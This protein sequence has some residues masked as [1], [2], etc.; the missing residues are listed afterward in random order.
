ME[1]RSGASHP[2]VGFAFSL[3][4]VVTASARGQLL[5]ANYNERPRDVDAALLDASRTPWVRGFFDILQLEGTENLTSNAN[6]A[7]MRRAADAGQELLVSLKWAFERENENVPA[8][9]SPR[10]AELFELAVD[11]LLAID[12]PIN[13]LVLGNEPMWETLH[14]DLQFDNGAVPYVT[15]TERLLDHIQA[16]FGT[17]FAA[18]PRYFV[19][20]LNRVDQANN[21]NKDVVQELLRITRED[22]DIAGLD[23]HLHF[24]SQEQARAMLEYGR[25]E[26]GEDKDLLVTE[27]SPVW[28]YENALNDP[29][30]A[31]LDGALFAQQFGYA[32]TLEVDEY[33]TTTY[34]DQVSRQEWTD[35]IESQPWYNENHIAD[36]HGMFREF[37]VSV[38]TLGFSQPLSFRGTNAASGNYTPFHINWLYVIGLIEGTDFLEAYNER[39]MDDWLA[40]QNDRADVDRNGKVDIADYHQIVA[41]IL[42]DVKGVQFSDS[43]QLGDVNLDR[44]I[45]ADDLVHFFDSFE[46]TNGFRVGDLNGNG[47]V[48]HGDWQMLLSSL[49]T[50]LDTVDPLLWQ[51]TGDLDGSGMVDRADFRIFKDALAAEFEVSVSLNAVA[52]FE[53]C[54]M[55]LAGGYVSVLFLRRALGRQTALQEGCKRSY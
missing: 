4:L 1:F 12:R 22:A 44:S 27:F 8:P 40:A 47:T 24:D 7:G 51:A 18:H 53:P 54:T 38:A 23:L 25:Q 35:F 26:I 21:Q 46:A 43:L 2:A 11:T 6:V 10:E 15:F 3:L 14:A 52:V 49:V 42:L 19:G 28:R 29:I 37:D 41:N 9:G 13:S 20:S 36:M 5:G 31:T 34:S 45:D 50:D 55:H 32:P 39:Y 16:E 33:L 30:G 48:E 17:Q